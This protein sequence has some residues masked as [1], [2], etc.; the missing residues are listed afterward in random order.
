MTPYQR[1]SRP[2]QPPAPIGCLAAT[3]A[4]IA[5][6]VGGFGMWLVGVVVTA[7]WLFQ[8]PTRAVIGI[9]ILVYCLVYLIHILR[10][11]KSKR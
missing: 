1:S 8:T 11:P 2:Y 9:T 7:L 10:K 4:F 3:L 6:I 5:V